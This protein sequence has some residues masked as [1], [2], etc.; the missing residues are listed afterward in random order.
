MNYSPLTSSGVRT[1]MRLMKRSFVMA[2]ECNLSTSRAAHVSSD[3]L[4]PC[5][6]AISCHC[7]KKK[8]DQRKLVNLCRHVSRIFPLAVY[9]LLS[10]NTSGDLKKLFL[11]RRPTRNVSKNNHK[12]NQLRH[13]SFLIARPISAS[14]CDRE[15]NT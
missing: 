12:T 6:L 7:A 5:K 3:A 2:R 10:L 8:G 11:G 4:M 14:H 9:C 13:E 15:K 1:I